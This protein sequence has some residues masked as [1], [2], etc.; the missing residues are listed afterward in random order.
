M[1][2]K[3]GAIDLLASYRNGNSF[4]R[5]AS[6]VSFIKKCRHLENKGHYFSTFYFMKVMKRGRVFNG[7][8]KRWGSDVKEFLLTDSLFKNDKNLLTFNPLKVC[9]KILRNI[10]L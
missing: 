1:Q 7:E 6:S 4:I 10:P 2:S 8:Q 5:T 9:F 3:S